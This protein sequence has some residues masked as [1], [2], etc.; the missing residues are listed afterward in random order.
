MIPLHFS[1]GLRSLEN[2]ECLFLLDLPWSLAVAFS[3]QFPVEVSQFGIKI[4]VVR[5]WGPGSLQ[6]CRCI[7]ET[8]LP[9]PKKLNMSTQ[10]KKNTRFSDTCFMANKSQPVIVF[11]QPRA[12]LQIDMSMVIVLYQYQPEEIIFQRL[13]II[14]LHHISDV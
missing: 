4:S 11:I 2:H 12:A 3:L 5:C 8:K 9:L 13:E 1:F 14:M 7:H 6:A 10:Y